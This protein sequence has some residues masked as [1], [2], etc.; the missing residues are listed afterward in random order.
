MATVDRF[1]GDDIPITIG[2]T[3]LDDADINI[4]DLT[5]LY[6]YVIHDPTNVVA[7]MFSKAGGGDYVALRKVTT[8][9]YIADWKSGSTK[10]AEAG[11]H[12][13][14]LNMVES[15]ATYESSKKNSI[16]SDIIIYMKETT[17][18]TLSSG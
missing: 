8:T 2:L 5:E 9:S 3:D 17:I 12:R 1:K 14:E 11:A 16:G 7:K 10:D 15:D 13:I 6:V 18:K 4:D